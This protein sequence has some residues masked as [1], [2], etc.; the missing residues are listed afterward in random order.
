M[1]IR[2]R[3]L[4]TLGLALVLAL[5]MTTV[6]CS[7]TQTTSTQVDDAE[8]AS[9]V[10]AKLAADPEVNPFDIDVDSK[11]G[12]VRL[13]GTVNSA[14]NREEAGRLAAGTEGVRRV[15]NELT[16][17]DKTAGEKLDDASIVTRVKAKLVADLEVAATNID[18]DSENGV[19]T[20]SGMVKSSEAR[21]QAEDLAAGTEGVRSVRNNITVGDE[22]M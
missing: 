18:V 11:D 20:L 3:T 7:T 17:G 1:R 21:Q 9:K 6:A 14:T 4:A 16:I 2:I 15:D 12:V 19:V 22:N 13:S 5:T 10:K 8:I